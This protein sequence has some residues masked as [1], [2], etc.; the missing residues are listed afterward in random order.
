MPH[1]APCW[2]DLGLDWESDGCLAWIPPPPQPP[3]TACWPCAHLTRAPLR[4]HW[5]PGCGQKGGARRGR[6]ASTTEAV[7]GRLVC[8][9]LGRLVSLFLRWGWQAG[10]SRYSKNIPFLA[11]HDLGLLTSEPQALTP[12][13][14]SLAQALLQTRWPLSAALSW[15]PILL[16][17]IQAHRSQTALQEPSGE[18]EYLWTNRNCLSTYCI[19]GSRCWGCSRDLN[20]CSFS[21]H[22]CGTVSNPHS[23]L[24]S[25]S[26]ACFK[27]ET[28]S[29]ASYCRQRLSP[30]HTDPCTSPPP[31]PTLFSDTLAFGAL[32]YI[33][34][35]C[36]YCSQL[37]CAVVYDY[38][39]YFVLFFREL[40]IDLF[41]SYIPLGTQGVLSTWDSWPSVLGSWRA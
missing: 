4:L 23:P 12:R 20:T 19:L 13:S 28:V 22:S 37:S 31:V 7:G 25:Q 18:Q 3:Q 5:K 2:T 21:W 39:F 15:F 16:E 29:D 27:C 38:T 35:L 30:L 33:L 8:R 14:S 24:T 41:S 26:H 34:W 40:I 9:A 11:F 1:G 32:V 10:Q 17:A 36:K 6:R